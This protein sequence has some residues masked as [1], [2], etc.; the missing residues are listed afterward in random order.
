[1]TLHSPQS[2]E[3]PTPNHQQLTW[4]IQNT[5]KFGSQGLNNLNVW[6]ISCTRIWALQTFLSWNSVRAWFSSSLK[7]LMKHIFSASADLW[8]AKSQSENGVCLFP[9]SCVDTLGGWAISKKHASSVDPKWY[10]HVDWMVCSL[11]C[12]GLTARPEWISASVPSNCWARL[13]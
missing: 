5:A 2:R 12:G 6:T 8:M 3:P 9:H 13:H 7:K 11:P 4:R 10:E 1:M